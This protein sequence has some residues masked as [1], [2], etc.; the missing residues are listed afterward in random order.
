MRE[1]MSEQDCGEGPVPLE[2][3][4]L[5]RA[6]RGRVVVVDVQAHDPE[7]LQSQLHDG[8]HA[9]CGK[10]P[11]PQLGAHPHAL[12]LTDIARGGTDVRL[13]IHATVAKQHEGALPGQQ[14][15]ISQHEKNTTKQIFYK[16][17]KK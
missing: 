8:G 3:D 17:H 1:P 14:K 15:N 16:Q 6:Q 13:E 4:P 12:D 11:A 10:T 2:A 5:V 7:A 9:R